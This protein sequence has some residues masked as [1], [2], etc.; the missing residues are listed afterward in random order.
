MRKR[1]RNVPQPRDL[2]PAPAPRRDLVAVYGSQFD[3]D[4]KQLE[5]RGKDIEKLKIVIRLICARTPLPERHLDHPLKGEW[6]GCRDCHI[7]PD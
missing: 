5:K 1:K 2:N 3:R 4:V 7:E 6:K